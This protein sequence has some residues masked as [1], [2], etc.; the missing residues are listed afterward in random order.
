MGIRDDGLKSFIPLCLNTH[1]QKSFNLKELDVSGV[2]EK[3]LGRKK[4]RRNFRKIC[5]TWALKSV[6]K[7]S[8]QA[9]INI[10]GENKAVKNL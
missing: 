5:L 9:I 6:I 3:I 4:K 1:T 2:L 10:S 7:S 8:L